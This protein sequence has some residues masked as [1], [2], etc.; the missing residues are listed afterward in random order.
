[1]ENV[2]Q[3]ISTGILQGTTEFLPVSS[4]GHLFLCRNIFGLNFGTQYVVL[5][6]L[7]TLIAVM[8]YFLKDILQILKGL[9]SGD[10]L[11]WKLFFAL[12][13]GTIPAGLLGYFFEDFFERYLTSNIVIALGLIITGILL[14]ISDGLKDQ[15]YTI[16]DI[17]IKFAFFIGLFQA[18]AI[19]PGLSRSGLTLFAGLILGVKRDDAFKFSF[20]LSIPVILGGYLLEMDK[21]QYISDAWLGFLFAIIAGFVSLWLLKILI[22]SKKL[23]FFAFYCWA[24]AVLSIVLFF[25]S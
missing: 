4:S 17:G 25:T 9:F 2:F 7:G 18:L 20:L 12:M 3:V 23:K 1:M 8:C 10:S 22:Q 19:M 11:S 24:I 6:H 15:K 21:M 14:Y 13:A 16:S 5:L